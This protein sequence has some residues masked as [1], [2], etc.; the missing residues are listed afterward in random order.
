[1]LGLN[2]ISL[3]AFTGINLFAGTL[4]R[5][6]AESRNRI[7]RVLCLSLL[8]LCLFRFVPVSWLLARE[9]RLPVEF[10]AVAGFSVSIILLTGLK[11]L[12]SWAAYSGILAGL[13]YYVVM[14]LAGGKIYA[15]YLPHEVYSSLFSH[16]TM[17]L[18]G[19]VSLRTQE[20][21]STDFY[22]LLAGVGFVLLNAFLFKSIA[23]NGARIFIYELMDGRY[24]RQVF[25]A[26]SW[27][28]AIPIYY[29]V[30][31]GLVVLTAKLFFKLNKYQNEKF[32]NSGQKSEY[33]QPVAQAL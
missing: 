24:I 22:K 33:A 28:Y 18:C 10:S 3:M 17:Y 30:M 31:T 26:A 5:F 20:F 23:D 19:I 6:S 1:M 8:F 21:K 14:M 2:V 13:C 27:G 12:Q 32:L 11:K 29:V 25:P 7:L 4:C 9:V 15:A 16:G